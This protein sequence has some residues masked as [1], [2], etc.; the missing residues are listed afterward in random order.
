MIESLLAIFV[1]L[2]LSGLFSGSETALT[3]ASRPLMSELEKG[4]N[5]RARVVNRLL[6]KREQLIGTILLGNNLV[7]ILASALATSV[8]IAAFGEAGVAYATAGMT[9]LV[10]IFAEI[11]PKTYALTH[12]NTTALAVAPIMRGLTWLFWPITRI[13]QGLVQ[14]MLGIFKAD[15][16][17]EKTAVHA[18][19]ELRGAIELHTAEADGGGS[20]GRTVRRERAMLKSVLDLAD[21]EVGEIVVHRSNLVMIDADLP[22]SEIVEQVLNSPFTRIPLWRDRMDNIVGIL[23]VKAL[24][25][26][27]QAYT[28]NL[29]ELDVIGLASP[30]WF[31]PETTTLLH[32]LQ[33]FR[34]RREH[35]AMVVDE[36]GTIMGVVTL[37]DI[38]EEIVGDISDEHDVQVAGVRAQGDGSYVVAGDVTIRDLNREFEWDLPD[39][40]A[41]T[42][43]GLILHEARRIPEPGQSF[44]FHGFRFEVLKR[45]RNRITSIRV[46]PG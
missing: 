45:V 31:I 16:G 35:F 34:E 3:A 26:A 18:L 30:T 39:D 2:V 33:A 12:T 9:I 42:L 29:D 22:A 14:V 4:G 46:V 17:Q 5:A 27:V 44:R 19:A 8:M 38:L 6:Q 15:A 32:Q 41:N 13:I 37:E 23:H 11:L 43:A 1:L 28:G 36:Y 21:V 25:R 20:G 40:V 10:L 24:L 7:N